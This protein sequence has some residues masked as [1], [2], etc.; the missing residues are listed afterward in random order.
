MKKIGIYSILLFLTVNVLAHRLTITKM[1]EWGTGAYNKVFVKGNYAYCSAGYAGVDIINIANPAN[2]KKTGNCETPGHADDITI[3]DNYAYV[4]DGESG[5]QV[6]DITSPSVPKSIGTCDT[7][8]AGTGVFVYGNYAYIADGHSGLQMID[9]SVPS[10]PHLVG[11]FAAPYWTSG[12]FVTGN[13]AYV[14]TGEWDTEIDEIFGELIIL[15]I[16]NP[17]SPNQVGTLKLSCATGI[18]VTGNYAYITVAMG[19]FNS[20]G[21]AI[22]DVKNPASPALLKFLQASNAG[23]NDIDIKDNYAYCA[24]SFGVNL[25]I[26]DIGNP[27]NPTRLGGIETP[28]Y[29]RGVH[30]SGNHAYVADTEGG[31]Q[32]INIA[33]PTYPFITGNYDHSGKMDY[34]SIS[35]NYAYTGTFYDSKLQVINVSVPS[36]P[37]Y[38]ATYDNPGKPMR[39]LLVKGKYAYVGYSSKEL[40]IINVTNPTAPFLSG[41]YQH[42][43]SWYPAA[44]DSDDTHAYVADYQNGLSII[45]ISNPSNP[46]AV[47]NYDISRGPIDIFV[48]GSYA[49]MAVLLSGLK[50]IDIS[51]PS[52]PTIVG[53]INITHNLAAVFV[54]GNYAYVASA[55]YTGTGG[56]DRTGR[57]YVIDVTNPAA[58]TLVGNI[59]LP[60]AASDVSINGNY[61]YVACG[62][63][64]LQIIDISK[65]A[66]PDLVQNYNTSGPAKKVHA[67]GNYI[68]VVNGESGKLLVLK[69]E[70]SEIPARIHLNRATLNFA[71]TDGGANTNPQTFFIT[72]TGEKKLEWSVMSN[73]EW[74]HCTPVNGTNN[75]EVTVSVNVSGLSAGTY[76]GKITV[77]G[78][79]AENSPQE[80][81]VNL[82]VYTGGQ[83]SVPFGQF[84]TPVDGSK[85]SNS[86]PVTGWALDDIAI[87]DVEIFH[88]DPENLVFI[89]DAFFV[90]GAR[91][92]VEQTYSAYP[93]NYK[94]GWGYMLLT[95]FLQ[96]GNGVFT[97]YAVA[98]DVEGKQVTLGTKTI[99]VDNAHAVKPFGAI[100]FPMQGGIASGTGYVNFGWVLTP[101]P[102]AIP[103]DGSTIHVWVDGIDLGTPVYNQYREDI[104]LFFPYYANS[105][106]AAGRFTFDTS[107]YDNGVHTIYWTATDDAGNSDGIGSRYFSIQNL[108]TDKIKM[109]KQESVV[110][111]NK[112]NHNRDFQ[113]SFIPGSISSLPVVEST[114]PLYI[115]KGYEK[116][117]KFQ[118]VY[119]GK[120]GT[121]YVKI[122]ELERIV[123]RLAA[124]NAFAV[125][126]EEFMGYLAIGNQ[127]KPLPL[128]ATMDIGRGIFY[129]QPGPGFIGRYS[130]VFIKK[131]TQGRKMRKNIVINISPK[132]S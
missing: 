76:T 10:S 15:D 1:G 74:L 107:H 89:G 85:V 16:S 127:L 115:G 20:G 21:L 22:I 8:G 64:G 79:G 86:I 56:P 100:D 110:F 57:L 45:D 44:I 19:N 40:Q 121:I 17:S 30:I 83:T 37:N 48:K 38:A 98:T 32:I 31:L 4:A 42:S 46:K 126:G 131:D 58:P 18:Y 123:I 113:R 61:A 60:D 3:K 120:N 5:L 28:G 119:P 12:V 87:K 82:K 97:L 118:Q 62:P 99:T 108:S 101:Q 84:D 69:Y 9:V 53:S 80:I 132:F 94:A 117:M 128:G 36:L 47:K 71:A 24:G 7:P 13:Y 14:I 6:I 39:G 92:D 29:G 54:K 66:A 109:G 116:D 88:G 33:D 91:P 25:A 104:A 34:L 78:P 2:P 102:N 68:Y 125:N 23:Y 26:F 59:A 103:V 111:M 130:L 50:V 52:S 105:G 124:E 65:P 63:G 27:T 72:N 55:D 70:I 112:E 106:G 73:R 90:E 122:K 41:T 51:N 43:R 81:A 35:S 49:Y 75:S 77:S 114:S 129:W 96:D 67:A 95:H 11:N 93:M